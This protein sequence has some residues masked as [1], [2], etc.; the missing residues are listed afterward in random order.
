M[1]IA[2]EGC[3]WCHGRPGGCLYCAEERAWQDQLKIYRDMA[4]ARE[5]TVLNGLAAG[6]LRLVRFT[7]IVERVN[8]ENE[9]TVHQDGVQTIAR[10]DERPRTRRPVVKPGPPLAGPRHVCQF[11]YDPP[12]FQTRRCACGRRQRF[13]WAPKSTD[14]NGIWVDITEPA[15]CAKPTAK[16]PRPRKRPARRKV[17]IL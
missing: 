9:F 3:R 5:Q 16:V 13:Q 12:N 4:V 11:V 2:Y 10:D 8:G 17:T 14:R 1:G 15:P 7:E 6:A